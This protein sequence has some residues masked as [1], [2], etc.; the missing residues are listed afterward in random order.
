MQKYFLSVAYKGTDYHGWQKQP[1]AM[2]VQ[3]EIETA[4]STLLRME[5]NILGS[6][7]TDAGVHATNQVFQLEVSDDTNIKEIVYR[8][9]KMLPAAISIRNF[10]EVTNAAHARFDATM[11]S[12]EYHLT[13]KKNP[14][15]AGMSYLF[16]QPLNFE[17]M[18]KAASALKEFTDFESFSRIKTDVNTFNC[19]IF[20]AIWKPHDDIWVFHI[21]ANRFLRGMVRAVVGTLLEVGLGNIT[22][23]DFKKIIA[24]KDRKLAGRSVPAAGL[25]LTAVTYPDTIYKQNN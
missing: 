5:T 22:I 16:V 7:R 12:Y 18:N 3:E 13:S 21:S 19:E 8:L 10:Q 1:N 4:L 14:F 11:R 6:G 24:A 9:N 23:T 15:E 25:F 20:D 2:T 17:L